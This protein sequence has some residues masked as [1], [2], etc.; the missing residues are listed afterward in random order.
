MDVLN[1][2]LKSLHLK[3]KCFG[4][5]E[6][7][8]PWGLRVPEHSNHAGFFIL[9]RGSCWLEL[10]EPKKE[11][12][13][14]GGD[15]VVFPHGIPYIVRD[16]QGS[17]VIELEELLSCFDPTGKFLSFGGGGALTS[18]VHGCFEFEGRETNPL[19]LALPEM[20]HIKGEEGRAVPWLETTLQYLASETM[21]DLPGS[22][23][24]IAHLTEIIFIQAVRAH[25]RASGEDAKRGLLKA[26]K[27]PQ[28]GQAL[29][30]IHNSPKESWTVESLASQVGMSRAG[31]AARFRDLV[32][33][34]P[35]QYLTRWRMHRAAELLRSG[36]RSLA[37]I[38]D[39][40]GYEA[41]A[42]FSKAFKRWMGS[43]PGT[44]RAESQ[45]SQ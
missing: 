30:F 25:I 14:A 1:E 40:V 45:A 10:T 34:P 22:E 16:K 33:E 11:V 6:F 31:F 32:G 13:I 8:A 4:R 39:E 44:Y 37:E 35:V 7:T 43:A 23:T 19:L 12:A 21:S 5:A 41:N 38:A 15:L 24:V 29:A 26:A 9:T 17:P 20:I 3:K 2:V 42:A 36:Q 28:I 27:D 18:V